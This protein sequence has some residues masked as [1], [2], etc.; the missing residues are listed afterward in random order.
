MAAKEANELAWQDSDKS[1]AESET[2]GDRSVRLLTSSWVVT[3]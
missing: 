1:F 2:P 3:F